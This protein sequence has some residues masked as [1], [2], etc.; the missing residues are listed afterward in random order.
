MSLQIFKGVGSSTKSV[1]SA[2]TGAVAANLYAVKCGLKITVPLANQNGARRTQAVTFDSPGTSLQNAINNA[3]DVAQWIADNSDGY[4]TM[5]TMQLGLYRPDVEGTPMQA[6]ELS[7]ASLEAVNTK[8]S[9]GVA[10]S[11]SKAKSIRLYVPFC[12]ASTSKASLKSGLQALLTSGKLGSINFHDANKDSFD[13]GTMSYVNGITIK[14][15]EAKALQMLSSN[16]TDAGISDG[17]LRKD[18]E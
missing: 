2:E 13:V 14:E 7:Y 15:Y 10:Q 16:D 11:V 9:S 3:A 17:I 6:G 5:F 12:K 18:T 1:Y 4:I 8:N